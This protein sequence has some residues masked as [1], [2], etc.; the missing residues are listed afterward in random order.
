MKINLKANEMVVKA[1]DSNLCINQDEKI[2]G[3]LILTNQRI[4]FKSTKGHTGKY[5]LEI[6]PKTIQDVLFFNTYL[7][8]R[9]GIHLVLKQGN[10]LRFLLKK[11]SQ[12]GE[13]I[14]SMS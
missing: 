12:W 14:A 9:N 6:D 11:R 5:D 10:E 8:L 7:F 3:K 13:M 1:T 2:K 4:Y